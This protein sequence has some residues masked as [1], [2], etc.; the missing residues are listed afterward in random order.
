MVGAVVRGG[1]HLEAEARA[2]RCRC[3]PG[4]TPCSSPRQWAEPRPPLRRPGAPG[5]RARRGRPA[6]AT[7]LRR[8][9]RG[10]LAPC[11]TRRSRSCAA[12]GREDTVD[13]DGEHFHY[14]RRLDRDPADHSRDRRVARWPRARRA[15][16]GRTAWATD[17]FRASARR[18]RSSRA[19]SSSS[20]PRARRGPRH[21]PG[22]LR[23]AGFYARTEIPEGYARARAQRNGIDAAAV[24]PS[25]S[26][27]CARDS[28]SSSRSGSRSSSSCRSSRC[29]RGRTS[30]TSLADTVLELQRA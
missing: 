11:S 21:R 14:R 7:G 28:T 16:P 15:P 18:S 10:T 1:A 26:M 9:P 22:A 3:S 25:A 29:P 19:A 27:R 8:G 23:C 30:S 17:G 24:V 4:A 5:V 20:K 13:H 12:C 6:G 2:R